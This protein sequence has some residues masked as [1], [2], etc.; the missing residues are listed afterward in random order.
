MFDLDFLFREEEEQ[1][2]GL[3]YKNDKKN[4][5]IIT[6][7]P[8]EIEN[9]LNPFDTLSSKENNE[10][11]NVITL[12]KFKETN[13]NKI[14]EDMLYY[15]SSN[16]ISSKINNNN[17]DYILNENIYEIYNDIPTNIFINSEYFKILD[18]KNNQT[19]FDKYNKVAKDK[20]L[21]DFKSYFKQMID[22][23]SHFPTCDKLIFKFLT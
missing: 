20:K 8:S 1:V 7:Y 5:Q 2:S 19:N 4:D 22:S 18:V 15:C 13:F 11:Q 6:E 21:D 12:R 14:K 3:N 10:E 9:L 23:Y 17:K 16:K